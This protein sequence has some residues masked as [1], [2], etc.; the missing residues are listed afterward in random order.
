MQPVLAINQPFLQYILLLLQ[1]VK[2]ALKLFV[3]LN[4]PM[5]LVLQLLLIM[6]PF[7]LIMSLVLRIH[8]N[9]TVLHPILL[10]KS[11]NHAHYAVTCTRHNAHYKA[12]NLY[13]LQPSSSS[14]CRLS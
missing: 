14:S 2:D 6:S 9:A 13:V 8:I 11:Q 4:Q 1:P 12:Q 5:L 7:L 3:L 10:I